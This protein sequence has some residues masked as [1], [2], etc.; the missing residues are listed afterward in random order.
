MLFASQSPLFDSLFSLLAIA[1]LLLA[2]VILASRWVRRYLQAFALQSWMIAGISAAVAVAGHYPELYLVALLT[3]LFRGCVLPWLLWRLVGRLDV[4]REL[5]LTIQA[6]TS[7]VVGAL[8]VLFA[9]VVANRLAAALGLTDTVVVLALTVMLAMD[10]I[11]FLM[12]AVRHEAISQVLGLLVLENGAFLGAQILI[13]GMPLFIEIV[14][15]FDVLI[16]VLCFGLL[17]RRLQSH[18]G[19]TSSTALRRLVG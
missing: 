5:H 2:F 6:S 3:V 14:L 19:A 16:M 4:E 10:L 7:L 17:A 13:P 12:L 15:L 9:L 8:A 18:L 1:S 11:G